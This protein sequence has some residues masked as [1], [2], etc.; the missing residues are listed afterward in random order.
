MW[1]GKK[2]LAVIPARGGSKGIPKKNLSLVNGESLI[3]HTA[4]IV[5]QASW[6]DYTII[7]T[8]DTE[9]AN[10]AKSL[11]LAVPFMRPAEYAGDQ[12]KSLDMWTSALVMAE[13]FYEVKFDYSILLEPTCPLRSLDDIEQ[14]IIKIDNIRFD[15]AVTVSKTPAH[16]SPQKTLEIDSCGNLDFF[17]KD[18][19]Q[20]D[21]RQNIP[22][23]YHRNGACYA[24]KRDV[25]IEKKPLI[26]NKCAAVLIERELV[27]IDTEFDL[28]L[29]NFLFEN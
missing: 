12:S 1:N 4:K 26:G 18:G 21:I 14:T 24:V 13:N 2:V 3:A 27:N 10:H 22:D 6:I 28:R 7:S 19:E 20:F 29:A 11:G 5:K 9:I 23:C 16:Y 17:I 15:T 25:L 8:D